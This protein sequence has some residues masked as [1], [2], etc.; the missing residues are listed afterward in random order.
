MSSR[1]LRR[2]AERK[3]QKLAA[4]TLKT[5]NIEA[6][7]NKTLTATATAGDGHQPP[8]F[9]W[10][11]KDLFTEPA[12]ND[13]ISD[14][15]LTANRA[16]SQLSTGP[17]T[18]EGKAKSSMNAVKTGL[19]GRTVLLPS[20]DTLVYQQHLDRLLAHLSPATDTEKSLVQ[21]IAD[22]EWRLLRIAPLEASIY[23]IARL[24]LADQF[25]NESDPANREALIL[26]KIFMSYRKDLSNLA[27]QERR[28]RNQRKADMAELQQLQ[29]ARAEKIREHARWRRAEELRLVQIVIRCAQ[30]NVEFDPANFGFDFSLEEYSHYDLLNNAQ[31]ELTKECLD[32]DEVL[33]DYRATRKEPEAA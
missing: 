9:D 5:A 10:L 25:P 31:Y 29:E 20:D 33:A 16:N 11:D 4:T 8:S 32:R 3:A 17:R 19:T 26:G 30:Q 24:E 21:T 23:A 18:P 1:A 12:S 2:A 6:P 7:A 14:A 27:L 22:T 15:R 28:L 13:Q